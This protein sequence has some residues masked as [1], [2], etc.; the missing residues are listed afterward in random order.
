MKK[1]SLFLLLFLLLKATAVHAQ[2]PGSDLRFIPVSP[3]AAALGTFGVVPTN[4]YVGQANLTIPIYEIDLDGKKFPIT[5]SYHTD[6][7]RV[8]QEA[9]WVGLGWTLQAGGCIIRQLQGLDDF[10]N[11]GH[12]SINGQAPW[13]GDPLFKMTNEN[14]EDYK[15]YFEGEYDAEPDIFYFSAGGYSGS[16]YFEAPSK[17]PLPTIAVPIIRSQEQMVKIEYDLE[18]RKWTMTD[19]EGYVYSFSKKE[20]TFPYLNTVDYYSETFPRGNMISDLK[21]PL[22]TTAWMLESVTSPNGRQMTFNYKM[23]NIYTPISTTEEGF[24]Y[25]ET[26]AGSSS[27]TGSPDVTEEH[28][29]VYSYSTIRQCTLASITFEGGIVEFATTDRE[30]IESVH[31]ERKVQKLSEIR[32]CDTDGNIVKTTKLE[33]RYLLSNAATTSHG[34]DDRLLLTKVCDTGSSVENNVFTMDYNMGTL[35]PKRSLSVDAWGFYNGASPAPSSRRLR[36]APSIYWSEALQSEDKSSLFEEGMDRSFNEAFCRIGTLRTITYPTGGTTTFE[37]EGHRFDEPPLIPPLRKS[38]IAS[39]VGDRNP[40]L[41]SSTAICYRS[42]PF[43]LDAAHPKIVIQAIYGPL[44]PGVPAPDVT[45]YSIWVEKKE[46]EHYRTTYYSPEWD[47]NTVGIEELKL[48]KGTY[49]VGLKIAGSNLEAPISASVEV[50]GETNAPQRKDYL[51]AGLR[52]KSITTTDGNGHSSWRRFEYTNAKMMVDPVF[53]AVVSRLSVSLPS[54]NWLKASYQ[55]VQSTPYVPLTSMSRSNLVGYTIVHECYGDTAVQGYI[56]Y[57]YHNMPDQVSE[58]FL[59]GVPTIPDFENG[60]PVAVTYLDKDRQRLKKESYIYS[61]TPLKV[62][63]APKM[64]ISYPKGDHEHPT[65]SL[66]RYRLTAQSFY[67]SRKTVAEYRGE[68]T[69]TD[70]EEY[71]YTDYGMLSSL[72]SNKHGVEK[73][74]L[75]QY[76]DSS[77]DYI[78]D[79]MKRK[80]MVGVPIERIELSGGKVVGASKTE[81]KDTLNMILPKRTLRF[82]STVPKTLADYTDAYVQDVLFG[83]YTPQG[84]PL[85]YIRNNLPVTFLWAYNGLYPVAKIEGKTYEE[86]EKLEGNGIKQ[87]PENTSTASIATLLN[88]VRNR[89]AG[90]HALI[91]TYLYQPLVGMTE[92]IAPNG[93]KTTF[94]YDDFSRLLWIKDHNGK[95]TEEY[96]YNY[97]QK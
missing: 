48:A 37:Y 18:K 79:R 15:H 60:K 83:K 54:H 67:L 89:L 21:T 6:G 84:R 52:L 12:Y 39:V 61:K 56:H 26:I 94:G 20:E 31:T 70:E 93:Q 4:N 14:Y 49:R 81:F 62:M 57:E 43:E 95:M 44:R 30:D 97:K 17:A 40:V 5:L 82:E 34:A 91:T 59:A 86:V 64:R 51:G 47:T 7:T 85:G 42:E 80:Y 46:G 32:V 92:T 45:G 33:Y 11:H 16:M 19:P 1:I 73:E 27:S 71:S 65:F 58:G 55:F 9:T 77:M 41:S 24:F 78:S 28:K 74:I 29:F 36:L 35:P 50:F 63:W 76:A 38:L 66:Q 23:E 72:K 10:G 69:V 22:V 2:V 8:A 3:N 53:N 90:D 25:G 87:L 68:D 75:T 96:E 88:S 13:A